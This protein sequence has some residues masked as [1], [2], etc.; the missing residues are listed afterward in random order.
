[1]AAGGDGV[2]L[3]LTEAVKAMAVFF[4]FEDTTNTE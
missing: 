2:N 3:S 4:F 1:M